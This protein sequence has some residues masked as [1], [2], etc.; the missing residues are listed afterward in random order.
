VTV[1]A[2]PL[3]F[4][5]ALSGRARLLR[6]AAV[7]LEGDWI[8]DVGPR[9]EVEAD[10][11]PAEPLDALLLPAL[12]NAHTHLELSHLAGKVPGGDG[13]PGWIGRFV[14][15]RAETPEDPGAVETAVASLVR[16]GVAAVGDVTNTLASLA[17][18]SRAGLT[19]TLFHEVFGL[20]A[21]RI[22]AARA[23]AAQAR[24]AHAARTPGLRIVPSPHAV[25]S[26]RPEVV[27]E[28]LASG[29]SSIHL[30]E[31][32]AERAFTA[33]GAGPLAP[34]MAAL[35][36]GEARPQ[37][38]SAVACAAPHL[39]TGNLAVHLVD[40]DG[41][42]RAE[43]RRSGATGVLCPRSNLHIGGR[44]PD[45]PRLLEAGVPLAVGTDSLASAPSLSPLAELA[46]LRSAFPGIPADRLL[47]LAWNGV[48]VGAPAVGWLQ[49][50][51]APG[52]LALPLD[53]ARPADPAAWLLEAAAAEPAFRW[54]A[55]HRPEAAG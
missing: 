22:G 51:L 16:H 54:L 3:V 19:G 35:G 6:D 1:V 39:R 13:L 5:G 26:T 32:P 46:A 2:A 28:L 14:R 43:L 49:P 34:L 29:P 31:D 30:A 42:D 18:V 15:A 20:S 47:P 27:G 4:V 10:H 9:A 7:A 41:E 23:A 37:G 55:R 11:G 21:A 12:V 25:Y 44:L 8:A 33:S 36:S 40:L 17:P 52:L 48:A 50:G 53:G 45:L 38:R 24:Q